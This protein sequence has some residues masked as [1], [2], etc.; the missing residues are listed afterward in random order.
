MVGLGMD[1]R[2]VELGRAIAGVGAFTLS[3]FLPKLLAQW[4]RSRELGLA[5]GVYNTG[6][7]LGSVICFGLFGKM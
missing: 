3:V 4:F 2:F 5:M 7:P 1:L 6:V